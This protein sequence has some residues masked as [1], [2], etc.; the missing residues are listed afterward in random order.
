LRGA[1]P[2]GLQQGRNSDGTGDGEQHGH[3]GYVRTS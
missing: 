1:A 2:F 3:D